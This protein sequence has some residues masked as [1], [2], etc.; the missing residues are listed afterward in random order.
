MA[1][2]SDLHTALHNKRFILAANQNCSSTSF[3]PVFCWQVIFRPIYFQQ[4]QNTMERLGVHSSQS[5]IE[6][7]KWKYFEQWKIHYNLE[8]GPTL[9]GFLPKRIKRYKMST[10]LTSQIAMTKST[11]Q[12]TANEHRR[13]WSEIP[14]GGGRLKVGKRPEVCSH[15]AMGRYFS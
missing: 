7:R 11:T 9:K 14:W 2:S 4:H 1:S 10:C 12:S 6:D 15:L 8:P 3:L 5:I 13:I